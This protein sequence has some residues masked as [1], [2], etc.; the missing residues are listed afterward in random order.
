MNNIK[1][2]VIGIVLIIVG[3]IV[4][5]NSFG[6]TKID[7]FFKGWWTLFI[8]VPCIV[9]LFKDEDKTGNLIGLAIGIVLLI[10][11]RDLISFET[12]WKL[13]LP[14]ILVIIGLSFIVKNSNFAKKIKKVKNKKEKN[15]IV[16]T[17]SSSNSIFSKKEFDGCYVDAIFGGVKIDLRESII[18]SD[19]IINATSIFGGIDILVDDDVNV[20][21]NSTSIFGGVENKT[22]SNDVKYTIYVN[23]TCLFGGVSIK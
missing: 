6:V 15:N 9:D 8:I 2:I 20:V 16:A 14:S 5:L 10:G 11:S 3:L 21:V 1:N 23:A 17:F 12:L 13:F 22:K 4:G 18:K 7:I 19:V